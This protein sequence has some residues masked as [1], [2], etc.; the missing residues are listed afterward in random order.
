MRFPS[1]VE[2]CEVC[3]DSDKCF[4]RCSDLRGWIYA[5]Q[6]AHCIDEDNPS[7]MADE[8]WAAR[9]VQKIYKAE[10]DIE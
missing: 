8:Y 4:Q 1:L 10:V 9:S 3:E 5:E 6:I 7:Y 2:M